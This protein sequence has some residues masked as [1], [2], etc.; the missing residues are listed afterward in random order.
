MCLWMKCRVFLKVLWVILVL[1]VVWRICVSGLM[2]VG[3]LKVFWNEIMF[4][5]VIV[6]WLNSVELL[7][8]VC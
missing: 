4:L 7:L 3:C 8:V 5:V 1:I 2:V 6:I